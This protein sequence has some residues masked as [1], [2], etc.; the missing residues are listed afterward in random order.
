MHF[1]K[2]LPVHF[3]DEDSTRSIAEGEANTEPQATSER[4]NSCSLHLA[5]PGDSV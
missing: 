3:S 2:L 5:L 4:V 1:S